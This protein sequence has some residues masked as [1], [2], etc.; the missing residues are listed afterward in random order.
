MFM[1]IS[2]LSCEMTIY[3][4]RFNMLQLQIA[5]AMLAGAQESLCFGEKTC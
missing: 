1:C 2:T 4:K 3:C 5:E